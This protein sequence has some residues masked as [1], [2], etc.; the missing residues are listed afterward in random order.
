MM[1]TVQGH[2]PYFF[3]K[4]EEDFGVADVNYNRYLNCLKYNDELVGNVMQIL[5]DRKLAEET[6]VVV[7]GDHGEAFGQ[8]GQYGHGTALYEENIKVP[9]YFINPVL[10]HGERKND[11]AG[12]KDL[13][14]TIFSIIGKEIPPVWQGRNLL[15]TNS[16]E[17][18]FLAPWSDYLFGYRNSNMKYIFNETRNSVEVFDLSSDPNE[19]VNLAQ[20]LSENEL[21]FA[22]NRVAAWVQFQDKFVRELRQN[23]K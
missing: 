8:H 23:E 1:W 11:I 17:A 2:Y 9:L 10:F 21:N 3:G 5:E 4:E 7:F 15:T 12:M 6:L 19:T 22:R 16:N 14:T 20:S 13:A 18:F